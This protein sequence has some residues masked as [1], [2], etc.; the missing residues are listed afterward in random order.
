M[1]K[2][3]VNACYP[4]IECAGGKIKLGLT[5]WYVVYHCKAPHLYVRILNSGSTYNYA[6]CG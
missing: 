2:V 3:K 4:R 1:I 5:M 6:R